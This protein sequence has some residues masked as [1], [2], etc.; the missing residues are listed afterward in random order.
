MSRI[1]ILT[2]DAMGADWFDLHRASG[3]WPNLDGFAA[4]AVHLHVTS[5]GESLHG[6]IWP[7]FATGTGPATHGRYFWLQWLADEMRLVRNDDPRFRSAPFWAALAPGKRATIVDLPYIDAVE[8]PGFRTLNGWGVHD[9]VAPVSVPPSFGPEVR[10]QFGKHPLSADTVEPASPGEKLKMTRDLRIGVHKRARLV[11]DLAARRDWGLLLVNFSES[12]KAGHYLALPETLS[13]RLTNESAY[14]ELMRPL[15]RLLPRII[16]A[17]GDDCHVFVVSMHGMAGR[18]DIA[19]LGRQVID[20][21]LGK[22][23]GAERER[24]DI[25]R[26]VR[27]LLPASLHR[28]IWQRLPASVRAGREGTRIMAGGYHPGDPIFTVASDTW[29]AVRLNLV[30]RERDGVVAPGDAAGWIDRLEA[31]LTE[32]STDD[33]QPAFAGLFRTAREL[34]GPRIDFL[35]DAFIR[36]NP[37]VVRSHTLR[38]ANGGI[39]R[40]AEPEARNGAHTGEGFCFW[41][42]AAGMTASRRDATIFDFAPS[43]LELL[44]VEPH[45]AFEGTSFVARA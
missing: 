4:S 20:V 22:D 45:S 40:T 16:R 3:R 44:G 9:E 7:S 12:H 6:S 21:L 41:R 27:N 24:S 1:L 13:P 15:D 14:G 43:L 39:L 25:V 10:R 17:A 38:R 18:T 34:S 19:P 33:D 42:P 30:G 32:F 28:A 5:M 36:T 31:L 23:P 35:P 26:K 2:L 29:P 11:E 8:E 37:G